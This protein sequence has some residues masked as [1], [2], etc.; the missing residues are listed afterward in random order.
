MARPR[1]VSDEEVLGA[2]RQAVLEEGPHVSLDLVASRLG[3]TTPALF[4]RFGHRRDLM[5]KALRVEAPSFLEALEQGPDDRPV[6]TQLTELFTDMADYLATVLPCVSALR[7]SGIPLEAIDQTFAEAQPL[8]TARALAGWLER[9][10]AAG[11]L[12]VRKPSDIAI[13]MIGALQSPVYFRHL[14]K[15]AQPWDQPGWAAQI[16]AL[17]VR[18]LSHAPTDKMSASKPRRRSP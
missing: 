16:A 1:R 8:A 12:E 18:G 17:F 9:A 11:L 6:Q 5:M 14:A 15:N 7:E 10:N 3:V 4:R 2:V 13:A